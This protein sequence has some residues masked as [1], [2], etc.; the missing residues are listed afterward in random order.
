MSDTPLMETVGL[1]RAFARG[2]PV[3]RDVSLRIDRG[4][5]V[6]VTGPSGCGKTTLLS[7]LGAIASP[8]SGQGLF[9]G[10][11]LARISESSRARIRRRI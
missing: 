3:L 11:D 8:T 5:F 10:P 9:D 6:A 2:R 1:T 7:L 4:E